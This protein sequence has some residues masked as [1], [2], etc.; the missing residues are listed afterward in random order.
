MS[1][2]DQWDDA[3]SV[4]GNCRHWQLQG[5]QHDWPGC[6]PL[7]QGGHGGNGSASECRR[8]SPI[9]IRDGVGPNSVWPQTAKDDS[10]GEFEIRLKSFRR[11][12]GPRTDIT[13][14]PLADAS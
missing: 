10:C 11:D 14:A 7:G 8:R 5:Y 3:A 4:C 2:L 1:W 9:A 6:E 13:G 12:R